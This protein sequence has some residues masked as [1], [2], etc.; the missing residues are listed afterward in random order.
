VKT[1]PFQLESL[2]AP[3]GPKLLFCCMAAYTHIAFAQCRAIGWVREQ[4][5]TVIFEV[6]EDEEGEYYHE[7]LT[8]PASWP[9]GGQLPET[10]PAHMAGALHA[11]STNPNL[12]N[13]E[14]DQS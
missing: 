8:T 13:G 7:G 2:A 11:I 5:Y 9:I 6:R 3:P 14:C 10:D 4:L 1:V 12:I